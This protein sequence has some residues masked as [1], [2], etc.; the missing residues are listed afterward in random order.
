M[1][2]GHFTWC[3][4]LGCLSTKLITDSH[5]NLCQLNCPTVVAENIPNSIGLTCL[6]PF[7]I[8]GAF[9]ENCENFAKF[10]WQ[11]YSALTRARP[12]PTQDLNSGL[13]RNAKFCVLTKRSSGPGAIDVG[14]SFQFL[15]SII[16]HLFDNQP[17]KRELQLLLALKCAHIFANLCH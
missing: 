9:S 6:A 14:Y 11:L 7:S 13:P 3:L 12:R 10:C 8:A 1:L 4:N 5:K 2:N 17:E 16:L 15:V